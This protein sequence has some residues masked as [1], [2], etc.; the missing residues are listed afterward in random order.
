MA[1]LVSNLQG[2]A[3]GIYHI[4]CAQRT[5][6]YENLKKNCFWNSNLPKK[7]TGWDSEQFGLRLLSRWLPSWAIAWASWSHS[8]HTHTYHAFKGNK[9][10][11]RQCTCCKNLFSVCIG[12][13]CQPS[14]SNSHSDKSTVKQFWKCAQNHS[15]EE[16][17]PNI[18]QHLHKEHIKNQTTLKAD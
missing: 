11:S 1:T 12:H 14:N 6:L 3:L 17:K 10:D 16:V 13:V 5:V 15:K 18:A 7:G 2:K 9:P 4:L 8:R